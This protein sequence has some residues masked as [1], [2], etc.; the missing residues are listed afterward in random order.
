M[1][2]SLDEECNDI[3]IILHAPGAS[4]GCILEHPVLL[5]QELESAR[6]LHDQVAPRLEKAGFQVKTALIRNH[7]DASSSIGAAICK[8]AESISASMIVMTKISKSALVKFF[9][10]S[11]TRHCV[12]HSSVPVLVC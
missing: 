8:Y 4:T 10:G 2:P 7:T 12:A 3:L 5:M 1:P 9:T 6:F 11:V